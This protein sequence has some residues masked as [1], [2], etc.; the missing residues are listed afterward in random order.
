MIIKNVKHIVMF[1][2]VALFTLSSVELSNTFAEENR[3]YTMIGDVTPV[4]TFTF[5]D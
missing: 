5:R 4:L 2:I 1:S 3:E